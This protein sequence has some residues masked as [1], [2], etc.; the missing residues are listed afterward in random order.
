MLVGFV[1]RNAH[2]HAIQSTYWYISMLKWFHAYLQVYIFNCSYLLTNGR[3]TCNKQQI[4]Q[5]MYFTDDSNTTCETLPGNVSRYSEVVW[6]FPSH[7]SNVN[8]FRMVL[9]GS[10]P[11]VSVNTPWF[12]RGENT[13][14]TPLECEVHEEVQGRG[15]VCSLTCLC[16]EPFVCGFLHY[17][18][19]FPFWNMDTL[20]LCHFE[21]KTSY[22][23]LVNPELITYTNN[24]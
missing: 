10:Q 11:C 19:Q 18:T 17:R 23:G 8:E 20:A 15:R 2:E 16:L 21:L 3:L 4:K 7:P 5:S 22:P 6:T 13:R 24:G 12:V 9:S 1:R 14:G